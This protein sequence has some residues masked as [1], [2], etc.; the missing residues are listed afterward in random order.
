MPSLRRF[1]SL[2]PF[3]LQPVLSQTTGQA[4]NQFPALCD[5]SYDN[6]TQLGAHNSPFLRDGQDGFTQSGNH[7]Y[8]TTVQLNAGVRLVTA[9][10][11]RDNGTLRLCHSNCQLLDAGP[12][13]DWLTEIRIWLSSNADNVVTVLLVNADS[14]SAT[15]LAA[16][17]S[18]ANAVNISYAP[19][20]S[21][22]APTTWPTLRE[23]IANQTRLITF[24]ASL[25]SP[26]PSAPYLLDEFTYLFESPYQNNQPSDL[27]RCGV[28]RPSRFN[29]NTATALQNNLLPL[30]NHF[31]YND[32]LSLFGNSIDQPDESRVNVTNAPGG[33]GEGNMGQK[34]DLCTREYGRAPWGILVDF[35]NVGPAI[36]TV[37]RLNGV[38]VP[39]G[40]Q[41]VGEGAPAAGSS[42]GS[43]VEWRMWGAV[44]VGFGLALQGWAAA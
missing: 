42:R 11:H 40:R 10:V 36:Q 29:G 43:R 37:D 5:R 8:N 17:Y 34:A 12:L 3:L 30:T 1:V 39:I 32:S 6:I 31:L 26:S 27:L 4:C 44:V 24:V 19:P 35:F 28:D 13:R 33:P 20:S 18:A 9:Q 25:P 23:L 16:E 41:E 2:L 15:D 7:Y 22:V 38:S 14:V 21:S